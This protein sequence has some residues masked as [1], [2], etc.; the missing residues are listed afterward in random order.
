M[1]IF[2]ALIGTRI[3]G[4]AYSQEKPHGFNVQDTAPLIVNGKD[5]F[6]GSNQ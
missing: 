3:S 5:E 1:K 4:D 2:T 6:V